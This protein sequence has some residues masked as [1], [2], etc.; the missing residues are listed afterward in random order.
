MPRAVHI[1]ARI[2]TPDERRT[3]LKENGFD[4]GTPETA[5]RG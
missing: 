2:Q 3:P 4:D 5:A 1:H